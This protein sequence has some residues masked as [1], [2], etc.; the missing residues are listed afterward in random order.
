MTRYRIASTAFLTVIFSFFFLESASAATINPTN[1]QI[2]GTTVVISVSSESGSFGG[3]WSMSLLAKVTS[4]TTN[5]YFDYICR[6]GTVVSDNVAISVSTTGRG[7]TYTNDS[8]S[9][10]AGDPIAG[11]RIF[12]SAKANYV[13]VYP[14][15]SPLATTVTP[16]PT[17]T[18][19]TPTTTTTTTPTT[20]TTTPTTTTTAPTTTT[21]TPTT[22]TTTTTTPTTT[23]TTPTTTTTTTTAPSPTTTTTAI[24]AQPYDSSILT[25]QKSLDR[26]AL[27]VVSGTSIIV[28]MLS[29]IITLL[30]RQR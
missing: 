5:V 20:T 15:G 2:A 16:T 13:S 26:I 7:K 27:A 10:V 11:A 28:F 1:G 22:T 3:T 18:T 14:N 25:N 6:S 9:C 29:I 17:T 19:T 4:G 23:T 12:D 21:T 8:G 24:E 30:F